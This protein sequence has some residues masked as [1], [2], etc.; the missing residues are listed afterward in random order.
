M[1][2]TQSDGIDDT[3]FKKV[4]D[5]EHARLFPTIDDN[6]DHLEC[7]D[8]EHAS[9]RFA[10]DDMDNATQHLIQNGFVVIKNVLNQDEIE[11]GKSLLWQF[12]ADHGEWDRADY[13]TWNIY[14][15]GTSLSTLYIL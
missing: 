3:K 12:M 2:N 13:K 1:G 6:K 9:Y 7:V 5:N 10:S 14:N 15:I 8:A 11:K 4:A